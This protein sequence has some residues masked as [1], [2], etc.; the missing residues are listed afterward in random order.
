MASRVWI[1]ETIAVARAVCGVPREYNCD[2]T[3]CGLVTLLLF[4]YR[5]FTEGMYFG[6]PLRVST[7]AM[8]ATGV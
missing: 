6:R 3:I 8:T 5:S 2:S 7:E 1:P 4:Y